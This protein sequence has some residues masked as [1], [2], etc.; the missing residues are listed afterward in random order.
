MLP[1]S[2]DTVNEMPVVALACGLL[3]GIKIDGGVCE[4]IIVVG[5]VDRDPLVSCSAVIHGLKLFAVQEECTGANGLHACGNDQ[6]DKLAATMEGTLANRGN[7]LGDH[8]RGDLAIREG[9]IGNGGDTTVSG[10]DACIGTGEHNAR[11][12]FDQ[13]IAGAVID[14]IA[15]LDDDAF[16]R[17]TVAESAFIHFDHACGNRDGGKRGTVI[18]R[19]DQRGDVFGE[20]DGYERI[21]ITEGVLANRCDAVGN[22]DGSK[23]VAALKG[24]FADR[25]E[26]V[27][28]NDRRD[29]RL[30]K[31]VI[32]NSQECIG[33][34]DRYK[35][36]A[37]ECIDSEACDAVTEHNGRDLVILAV[38][39]IE[40]IVGNGGDAVPVNN[41]GDVELSIRAGS[42]ACYH[43][44]F[45]CRVDFNGKSHRAGKGDGVVTVAIA[46]RAG[47]QGVAV[48]RLGGCYNG[49]GI[50]MAGC[51]DGAR[52]GLATRGALL[53]LCSVLCTGGSG[54]HLPFTPYVLARF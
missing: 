1:F 43:A 52:G 25:L 35:C 27:G 33:E 51:F 10:K 8:E 3:C 17:A 38:L 2:W 13:T 54:G 6:V 40:R 4:R 41:G 24:V 18:K 46:A 20:G 23:V 34:C 45:A 15:R 11:G 42:D 31:T 22:N 9:I 12:R 48:F 28:Q 32:S 5:E 19:T 39:L 26:T 50:G 36:G 53:A 47:M 16:K 14:R 44:S 7:A 37:S 30:G 49:I 29:R 21:T